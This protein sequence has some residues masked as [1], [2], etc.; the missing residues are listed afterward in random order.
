MLVFD[1]E[2]Y[3]V[4]FFLYLG[5]E[6][7]AFCTCRKNVKEDWP[8]EAFTEYETVDT[9]GRKENILLAEQSTVL[10]AKKEKGIPQKSVTVREIRKRSA[11]GHQTAII[12]TNYMK[13]MLQL[14]VLMF[15]RWC[16]ENFFKYITE[17]FGI[18]S[19]ISYLKRNLPDT[20]PIINPACKAL[21]KQQKE[22]TASLSKQKMKYAQISLR[23]DD[24]SEKQ[25]EKHIREKAT[26]KQEID[27]LQKKRAGII[28]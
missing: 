24:L 17:S 28:A 5:Q 22:T 8:E 6:R 11:W 19:I 18:D 7:I 2:C 13:T 23:E 25:M 20:S 9:D 3:S 26:V 21:V 12:T 10:Y 4:D 1:R 16:Q 27:A 15:A 14:A